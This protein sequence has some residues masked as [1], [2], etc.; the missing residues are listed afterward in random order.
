M[1]QHSGHTRSGAN[2]SFPKAAGKIGESFILGRCYVL[3]QQVKIEVRNRHDFLQV[4]IKVVDLSSRI[5]EVV[6]AGAVDRV[7]NRG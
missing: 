3:L 6:Y 2:I 4:R 5:L 7:N 1:S